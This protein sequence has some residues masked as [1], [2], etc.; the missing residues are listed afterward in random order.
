[1]REGYARKEKSRKAKKLEPKVEY[2]TEQR[3]EMKEG[4]LPRVSPDNAKK[5]NR[6]N[7]CG[8]L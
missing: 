1:M 5:R 7:A 3:L 2:Q 8:V 4:G 6:V